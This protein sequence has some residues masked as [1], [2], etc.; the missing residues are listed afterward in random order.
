MDLLTEI[1]T[2]MSEDDDDPEDQSQHLVDL[3]EK[4]DEAGKRLI[5]DTLICVCG[6]SLPSLKERAGE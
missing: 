2:L 5:D 3:Y 6:Y 1:Y 4:A